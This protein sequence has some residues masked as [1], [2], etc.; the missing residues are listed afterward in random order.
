VAQTFEA[1][2]KPREVEPEEVDTAR[3]LTTAE[4][5]AAGGATA[6]AQDTARSTTREEGRKITL[7]ALQT[8]AVVYDFVTRRVTT[9]RLSNN[10]TSDLVRG[11]RIQTEHD[12]FA[13]QAD[14]GRRFDPF[15]SGV[16]VSFSLGDRALGRFRGPS[17]GVARGRGLLPQTSELGA[18]EAEAAEAEAAPERPGRPWTA[19]VDYSLVR[20]RPAPGGQSVAQDRQTLRLNLGLS[21]TDNWTV[22]WRTLYDIE[23]REFTDQVVSL[24]RD[25][26]RWSATFDFLRAANG[27]FLFEFR[28]NL[29]DLPDLKF[30]YR[31]E[32]R[33]TGLTGGGVQ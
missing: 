12:L 33:P 31:Q 23:N 7:L 24:R 18:E 27:N 11:L 5:D 13:E 9:D 6:A 15:L 17:Q 25:L 2:L 29:N 10:L 30:D 26:H 1:K 19:S 16:N 32:S 4:G 8:S 14:G 21:P 22:T 3:S 20:Q 28:V